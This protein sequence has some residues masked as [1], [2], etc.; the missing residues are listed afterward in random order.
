[1][2]LPPNLGYRLLPRHY[3]TLILWRHGIYSVRRAV[4][5]TIRGNGSLA[6]C[7][8]VIAGQ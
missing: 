7:E 2:A 1:M 6:P 8:R 4:V 3:P 5:D